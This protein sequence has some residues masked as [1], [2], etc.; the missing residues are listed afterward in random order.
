GWPYGIFLLRQ[1]FA[2]IPDELDDAAKIDG[3]SFWGIFLRIHLPLAKPALG[4]VG[5]LSFSQM[6][7]EY[8][9]PLI[10]LRDVELWPLSL[11]LRTFDAR[12]G[13][14]SHWEYVM[15]ISIITFI[16]PL[17]LFFIAQRYYIQG[18]VISG[19]KG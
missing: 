8:L 15:V 2:G 4:I 11:A 3:A 1:F 12:T 17:L 13:G 6:W 7:N 16:P 5:I 18:I 10:Y 9:R 19:I 14:S